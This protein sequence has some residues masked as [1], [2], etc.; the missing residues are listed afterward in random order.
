MNDIEF[1]P[2][3][4]K[5]ASFRP[6]RPVFIEVANKIMAALAHPE[7]DFHHFGSTSFY[8]AGKGII[9]LAILYPKGARAK[10][11]SYLLSRG[12]ADQHSQNPFPATRPRK[13]IG[14]IYQ[15]EQ[16]QIH[17]HV[18][19]INSDEHQKQVAYKQL[20][21]AEPAKRADYEATKRQILATGEIC[22]DSY[23]KQ[24][25]PFVKDCLL[26]LKKSC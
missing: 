6:W 2:Y 26:T 8:V 21:L 25:S 3:Q 23:S 10:A 4:L 16:F 20:M 18:I 7:F 22:Q 15:Q 12:F 19:E 14:V 24:K 1:A 17:C 5:K 9:D 13:D 11:T